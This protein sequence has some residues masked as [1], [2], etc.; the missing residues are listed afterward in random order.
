MV[1]FVN[2]LP[3]GDPAFIP[4]HCHIA[5]ILPYTSSSLTYSEDYA[6]KRAGEGTLRR[7]RYANCSVRFL[8]GILARFPFRR[9]FW[10]VIPCVAEGVEGTRRRKN[11]NP[12]ASRQKNSRDAARGFAVSHPRRVP[13]LVHEGCHYDPPF[14]QPLGRPSSKSEVSSFAG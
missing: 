2:S 12:C 3:I 11:L 5:I 4:R 13:L 1:V 8:E 10:L 6:Y 14:L 9:G 7:T